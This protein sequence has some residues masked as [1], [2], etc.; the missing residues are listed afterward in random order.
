MTYK[1]VSILIP[2]Y[3]KAGHYGQTPNAYANNLFDKWDRYLVESKQVAG[4]T[5]T[6]GG[7]LLLDDL[8]HGLIAKPPF[9]RYDFA[10]DLAA[11]HPDDLASVVATALKLFGLDNVRVDIEGAMPEDWTT[12]TAENWVVGIH[13]LS[14]D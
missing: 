10:I 4:P 3:Q 9:V 13:P 1:H 5:K 14:E 7:E 11:A 6:R 8:S 2:S 12:Q